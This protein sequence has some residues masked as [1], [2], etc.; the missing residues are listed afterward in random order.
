MKVARYF[1]EIEYKRE[2]ETAKKITA[3]VAIASVMLLV[4]MFI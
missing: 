2:A 4:L 1:D 3:L